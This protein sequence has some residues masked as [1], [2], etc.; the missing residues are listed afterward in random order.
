MHKL[1]SSNYATSLW[2]SKNMFSKQ[3]RNDSL[4]ST[5]TT[6]IKLI[7]NL[8]NYLLSNIIVSQ[9]HVKLADKTFG[10]LTNSPS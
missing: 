4:L 5:T 6:R 1:L 7:H 10:V 3:H 2:R 8:D 9:H